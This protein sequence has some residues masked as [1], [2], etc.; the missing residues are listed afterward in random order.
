MRNFTRSRTSCRGNH[1]REG[2]ITDDG[3]IG[4]KV[5][6][7]AKEQ[8]KRDEGRRLFPYRDTRNKLTIGY[9]RNLDD[10]GIDPVEADMMLDRDLA[11]ATVDVDMKIPFAR[12]LD[13]ARRGA[14]INMTYNMGIG[15][16]LTFKKMLTAMNKGN[17]EEAAREMLDSD[18]AKQVGLRAQ[19]LAEQMRKGEWV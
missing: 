16:L 13:D 6:T 7:C 11:R 8:I 5:I 4:E 1:G 15:G 19:R 10:R 18:Y 17:W 9:G 2:W 12:F 3:K 14:L